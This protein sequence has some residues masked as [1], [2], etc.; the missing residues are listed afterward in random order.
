MTIRLVF[1]GCCAAMLAA[2][3][4]RDAAPQFRGFDL[5][6]SHP[7]PR[8]T[9]MLVTASDSGAKLPRL[10]QI[11]STDFARFFRHSTGCAPDAGKDV[12]VLGTSSAPAGYMVPFICP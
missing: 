11:Q 8:S 2:C 1:M 6:L 12:A 9:Y 4:T 10:R 3:G 7:H 5:T